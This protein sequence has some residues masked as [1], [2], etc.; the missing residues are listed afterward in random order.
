MFS[1]WIFLIIFFIFSTIFGIGIYK[2]I[3]YSERKDRERYCRDLHEKNNSNSYIDDI[4]G[5]QKQDD[6][7]F[8]NVPEDRDFDLSERI[9]L[10]GDAEIVR[11]GI[12]SL[13]FFKGA[14]PRIRRAGSEN[15]ISSITEQ[16]N[17]IRSM[18]MKKM[19]ILK[20]YSIDVEEIKQYFDD[21][22]KP[23]EWQ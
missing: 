16:E 9:S 5:K 23:E 22:G 4:D 14:I 8:I 15:E 17:Y 10:E 21:M 18:V 3:R 13:R 1:W 19:N 20:T 11:S 2:L 6:V 7:P 12:R